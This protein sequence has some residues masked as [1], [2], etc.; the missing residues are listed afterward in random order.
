MDYDLLQTEMNKYDPQMEAE[1]N[2]LNF[3]TTGMYVN[4]GRYT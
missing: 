2:F 3:T 1:N 4:Y